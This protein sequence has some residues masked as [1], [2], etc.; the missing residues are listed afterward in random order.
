VIVRGGENLS[1]GEIE[2]ALVQHPAVEEAAV[3]GIPDVEWGEKV[4]AAVVLAPGATVSEDD[5]KEFVRARLRSTKTPER[6]EVRDAL[7][8]SETGKLLRRVLR[9]ELR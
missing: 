3:V 5:L 9:D 2:S 1:P 4:V 7:P 8:F 6:I